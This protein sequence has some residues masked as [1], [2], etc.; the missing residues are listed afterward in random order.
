MVTP[1]LIVV[2]GLPVTGVIVGVGAIPGSPA[3]VNSGVMN[4]VGD[5]VVAAGAQPPKAKTPH[6]NKRI[7]K[8]T[9]FFIRVSS[10]IRF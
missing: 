7:N 6:T 3:G 8:G 2:I 10:N 4:G 1:G 5:A 9:I